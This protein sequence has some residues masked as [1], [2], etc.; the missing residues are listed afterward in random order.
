MFIYDQEKS[1]FLFSGEAGDVAV[2]HISHHVDMYI[3]L[4]YNR[5]ERHWQ[6]VIYRAKRKMPWHYSHTW[7]HLLS[8]SGQLWLSP[9]KELNNKFMR[10]SK[11]SNIIYVLQRG[12]NYIFTYYC[13]VW[14]NHASFCIHEWRCT[15][16]RCFS[17]HLLT[18]PPSRRLTQNRGKGHC[19]TLEQWSATEWYW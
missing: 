2:S 16:K 4:V 8:S 3:K 11:F 6:W 5:R 17:T 14:E 9:P 7:L 18:K 13:W 19:V 1:L 15:W 10:T 12:C